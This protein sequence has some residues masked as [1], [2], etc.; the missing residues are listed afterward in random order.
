MAA[1]RRR[2]RDGTLVIVGGHERKDS[3]RSEILAEVAR[4]AGRGLLVVA[5]V[6]TSEPDELWSEY[7]RLFR[8]L[9]VK[10]VE[11]LDV[12][13]RSDARSGR[14][15]AAAALLRRAKVVFFTGGDQLR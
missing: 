7:R 13:S 14:T 15:E 12:H 8:A 2:P 11:H 3:D 6:A 4:R 9:G 10:E 5:T 1:R